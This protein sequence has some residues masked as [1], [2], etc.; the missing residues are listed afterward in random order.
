MITDEPLIYTSKGNLPIKDL[1]YKHYRQDVPGSVVFVEEYF[2]NS[3]SVK[4]S[5]HVLPLKGICMQSA[6]GKVN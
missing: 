5:V 3:E 2:L 1:E 6:A 4:R